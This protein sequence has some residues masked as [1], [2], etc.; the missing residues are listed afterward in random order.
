V[1]AM[2]TIHDRT[3]W[4]DFKRS[5]F[6][7]LQGFDKTW[8]GYLPVRFELGYAQGAF[9]VQRYEGGLFQLML[10][11][12]AVSLAV[13][14]GVF[15]ITNPFAQ[16]ARQ[17]LGKVVMRSS[18]AFPSLSARCCS[19]SYQFIS[20]PYLSHSSKNAFLKL[21]CRKESCPVTPIKRPPSIL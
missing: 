17:R 1:D 12:D 21:L 14:Q 13:L 8:G 4:L 6:A 2:V 5:W 7:W 18:A 20:G 11:T 9:R 10:P 3:V 19:A 16:R 15:F